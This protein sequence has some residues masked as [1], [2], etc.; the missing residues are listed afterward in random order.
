CLVLGMLTVKNTIPYLLKM[1]VTRKLIYISIGIY[2]LII[3]AV[4]ALLANGLT[5][6]IDLIGRTAVSGEITFFQGNEEF[7]FQFTHLSQFLQNDNFIAQV[8]IDGIIAFSALCA[9]FFI[10]LIFY[11]FGLIG[12]FTF[13]GVMFLIYV[14]TIAQGSFVD[15]VKY[16]IE[17]YSMT[18]YLQ[19]FGISV[20]IYLLSFTM[21]RRLTITSV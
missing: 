7:A 20:G 14:V 2:F 12:G 9:M 15:F 18:V 10:G 5:K 13:I 11:R 8:T 4:Q 3:A 1:S 19:L 16:I 17:N 6:I 21:L